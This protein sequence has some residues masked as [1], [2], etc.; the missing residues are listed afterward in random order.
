MLGLPSKCSDLLFTTLSFSDVSRNFRRTHNLTFGTSDWRGGQRKYDQVPVLA[1]ANRFIIFDALSPPDT[2]EDCKLFVLAVG[3][4]QNRD[5]LA[6]NFFRSVAE[7]L[8]C[9]FIPTCDDTMEARA[10][11]CIITALDNGG[12]PP[13]LLVTFAQRGFGPAAFDKIGGLSGKQ[14]Q[15]S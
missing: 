3:W 10:V 4:D 11:D 15:S 7:D 2:F 6:N 8:L 9:A 1:L 5:R 13:Q 14:I 12:E